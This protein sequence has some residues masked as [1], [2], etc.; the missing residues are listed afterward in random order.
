MDDVHALLGRGTTGLDRECEPLN[1]RRGV[2][3]TC[4]QEGPDARRGGTRAYPCDERTSDARGH[5]RPEHVF[6][7]R[8]PVRIGIDEIQDA[9]RRQGAGR[10]GTGTRSVI[11]WYSAWCC[12]AIAGHE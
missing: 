11:A 8:A 3:L 9:R 6:E 1:D 5:D 12:A 7:A 4:D 2:A 10:H